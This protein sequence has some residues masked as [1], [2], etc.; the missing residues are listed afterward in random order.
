MRSRLVA[1][2]VIMAAC[3]AGHMVDAQT[4]NGLG[5]NSSWSTT[6]NWSS[7]PGSTPATLVFAGTTGTQN[8]NDGAV[9]SVA[10]LRIVGGTGG[11]GFVLSGSGLSVST[12]IETTNPVTEGGN[13]VVEEIAFPIT[14]GSALV[15]VDAGG[16][17]HW[18]RISGLITGG[19]S[20]ELRKVQDNGRL[21]LTAD[22][23][24]TGQAAFRVGSVQFPR[25]GNISDPAPLG[26][27]NLPI[28]VGQAGQT[29]ELI[30]D[31]VGE[32]TNRYIQVGMGNSGVGGATITN[33]GSG[34][35]VFNATGRPS[36]PSYGNDLFNQQHT[37]A[38]VGRTLTFQGSNTGSNTVASVVV[39]NVANSTSG[40][41]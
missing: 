7:P 13:N 12:L 38:T 2:L 19:G 26:A 4:W 17:G 28:Q 33:N 32:S 36:H 15:S 18:L 23:T 9:T 35:L 6:G 20:N 5:G 1:A 10:T 21:F 8:V 30:Y 14:L 37:T 29:V 25:W 40:S 16:N 34:P 39:D 27:G 3:T 31:G 11:G 22:N 24:F 41:A